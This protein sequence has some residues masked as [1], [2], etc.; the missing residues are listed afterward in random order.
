VSNIALSER[1]KWVGA[2]ESAALLGASPYT[3]KFKLWHQKA[4]LLPADDLDDNERVQAGQFMEPSIAA[5]AAHKWDLDIV[6]VREYRAN[7]RVP[8][9][10]ASL[11]YM[12]R[13]GVPVEIKNVDR[14]VFKADFEAEKDTI[15]AAPDHFLIQ[16]QHQISCP[17][18]GAPP[19]AEGL[20]IACVGGNKLY[21]MPI[22]RH[23]PLIERIEHEVAD[24]WGSI[25]ANEPP[26]PD[27]EQ[28]AEAI[29]RLFKGTGLEQADLSGNPRAREIALAY[30]TAHDLHTSAKKRK[31]A[32]LAELKTLLGDAQGA[33]LGGGY[34]VKGSFIKAGRVEAY[35]REAYWRF[36]ISKAKA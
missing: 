20:L 13:A 16:V 32:L 17:A 26:P 22:P 23:T 35:D 36:A 5:W 31:D 3:T 19:T 1:A 15:V 7:P 29:A 12:T 21:R 4:G 6:K 9:M 2:S 34:K 33:L 30:L 18:E 25:V 8:G 10:G 27:F 11:D 28:D 14:S 24:F